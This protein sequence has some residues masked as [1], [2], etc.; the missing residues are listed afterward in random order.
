MEILNF[1]DNKGS[2]KKT[3]RRAVVAIAALAF[4]AV[5]STFAASI[6]L[7]SGSAVE[8]GQGLQQA[9]ACDSNITMTP[10]NTYTN[11]SGGTGSFKLTSIEFIDTNTTAATA[12]SGLLNCVGKKILVSAYD[13]SSSTALF[14]CDVSLTGSSGTTTSVVL[15]GSVAS[16]TG[17]GGGAFATLAQGFKITYGSATQSSTGVYKFTLESHV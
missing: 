8:Y 2:R 9:T 1:G 5:G 13:D 10:K 17:N 16:C 4:A 6:T 11:T 12:N 15:N 7:N 3:S 14:S